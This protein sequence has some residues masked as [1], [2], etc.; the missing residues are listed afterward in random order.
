MKTE[1]GGQEKI[2]INRFVREPKDNEKL[3]R[4]WVEISKEEYMHRKNESERR[5]HSHA[6]P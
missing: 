5:L 4:G 6:M 1:D 2:E 3:I